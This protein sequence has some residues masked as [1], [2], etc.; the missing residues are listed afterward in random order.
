MNNFEQ[1][2][3][4][5]GQKGMA[6]QSHVPKLHY[7]NNEYEKL[8]EE[9]KKLQENGAEPHKMLLNENEEELKEQLGD[10]FEELNDMVN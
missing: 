8:R 10:K 1:Y 5:K 4:V 9:N 2:E 6:E 7:L 3:I